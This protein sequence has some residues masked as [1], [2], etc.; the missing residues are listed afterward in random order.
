MTEANR[1]SIKTW[2]VPGLMAGTILA[3]LENFFTWLSGVNIPPVFFPAIF[4]LDLVG[5]LA[6]GSIV[7]AACWMFR[8]NWRQSFASSFLP[9]AMGTMFLFF[10]NKSL[11]TMKA[12]AL[13]EW[14]GPLALASIIMMVLLVTLPLGRKLERTSAPD[15]SLVISF[16]FFDLFLVGG[17]LLSW[18]KFG[19]YF[20]KNALLVNVLLAAVVVVAV[21]VQDRILARAGPKCRV[22]VLWLIGPGA[23]LAGILSIATWARQ[24]APTE[25][26][27]KPLLYEDDR[28]SVVLISIDTLRS[29]HLSVYGYE[30]ETTPHLKR[31]ASDGVLFLNALS[32]SSWTLPGHASMLAGTFPRKHSAHYVP[33]PNL[34]PRADEMLE[35][36]DFNRK[37]ATPFQPL[38]PENLTLAE[39]LSTHGYRT[40]GIVSN[41][42]YLNSALGFAQGFDLYD[43]S[44]GPIFGYRPLLYEAMKLF[45]FAFYTLTKPYRVAEEINEVALEW[46]MK[47]PET[48]FFLFLNYMEPHYP[49]CAPLPY[50]GRFEPEASFYDQPLFSSLGGRLE[51]T[52]D[53]RRDTIALYDEEI[54]YV[55]NQIGVLLQRLRELGVYDQTLIIVTSDHGEFFGEHGLWDHGTGPYEAVHRVPLIVKYPDRSIQ[56]VEK[57]WVETVDIFPTVLDVVGI[58]LPEETQGQPLNRVEHPI[59]TEHYPNSALG[60][61]F[62]SR[63][64]RGYRSLYEYPWKLVSYMDGGLELFDLERDPLESNDLSSER[65]DL[66]ERMRQTLDAF[67]S[68]TTPLLSTEDE[69]HRLDED[70]RRRL[71]ALGYLN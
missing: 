2:I 48:P 30:R 46:L 15:L 10:F 33:H 67:V 57:D 55:D 68:S 22:S 6:L 1:R 37:R 49:N 65:G 51:L 12:R 7:G 50:H 54:A 19:S 43:D 23:G 5:G 25:S 13:S 45:P 56:G 69:G 20:S 70:T 35:A 66:V 32:P 24:S 16:L 8:L 42:G 53:E 29:D 27:G 47:R 28:P 17:N 14:Y 61:V 11:V 71:K 36:V 21:L 39:V 31:L 38:L 18:A 3:L 4:L 44:S 64:G 63:Y 59:I 9:I 34:A 41:S 58:A 26:V 62:G 52:A 40:A 60:Q